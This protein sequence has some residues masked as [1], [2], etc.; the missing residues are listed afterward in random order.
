MKKNAIWRNGEFYLALVLLVIFGVLLT[1]VGSIK[2]ESA[3]I[4]PYVVL[5]PFGLSALA[6]LVMSFGKAYTDVKV[7]LFS[8]KELITIIAML[9]AALLEPYIGLLPALFLLCIAVNII[10]QGIPSWKALVK[11]ILFSL[12]FI[13]ICYLVFDAWL[14]M[15]LPAGIWFQ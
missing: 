12:L 13:G 4:W 3:R 5:V 7:F 14:E 2:N 15:Y 6:L 11:N 8:R 10:I 9:A 1:S